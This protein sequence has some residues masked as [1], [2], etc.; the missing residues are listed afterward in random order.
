MKNIALW[1]ASAALTAA[2]PGSAEGV[3]E[4]CRAT[5]SDKAH[6]AC[7]EG[8]V[9]ALQAQLDRPTPAAPVPTTADDLG[10]EQLPG[11]AKAKLR[12]QQRVQAKVTSISFNGFGKLSVTLDNGQRWQQLDGDSTDLSNHLRD[13]TDVVV[14]I[15]RSRFGG[16]RMLITPPDK[17]IRV[18]RRE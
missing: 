13:A 16:Y 4:T 2:T 15:T 12:E 10:A 5:D 17:K 14:D 6:I 7:L 18:R 8:A 9:S 1:V 3:L 11:E